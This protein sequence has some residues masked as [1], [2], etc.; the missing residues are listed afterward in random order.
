MG[1]EVIPKA[2]EP[3]DEKKPLPEAEKPLGQEAEEKAAAEEQ[4]PISSNEG[5][6]YR[7]KMAEGRN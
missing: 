1:K 3:K 4:K 6:I 5:I 7:K 2:E